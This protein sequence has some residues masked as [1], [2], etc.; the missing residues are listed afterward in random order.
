[1]SVCGRT[2]IQRRQHHVRQT[3][4][5]RNRVARLEDIKVPA[6]KAYDRFLRTQ[7]GDNY[8]TPI[9]APT[10][11]GELVFDTMRSYVELLPQV[12]RDY[13]RSAWKRLCKKLFR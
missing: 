11:H 1:M 5:R 12:R 7:Y 2:V 3:P 4:V 10:Y 6:P 9:K 8:M 13:R